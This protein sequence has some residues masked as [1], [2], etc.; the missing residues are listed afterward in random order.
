MSSINIVQLGSIRSKHGRAEQKLF[1]RFLEIDQRE[2]ITAYGYSVS[3]VNIFL[4]NQ[5]I[6][7]KNCLWWPCLLM[8]QD[9]MNT[10]SSDPVTNMAA[11][12]SS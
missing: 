6:S 11:T 12:G 10:C 8:D 7:N 1:Q 9:E 5:P 3:E 2:T 4:R